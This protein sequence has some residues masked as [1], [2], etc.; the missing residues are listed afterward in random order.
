MNVYAIDDDHSYIKIGTSNLA[1]Q[2]LRP[3]NGQLVYFIVARDEEHLQEIEQKL[4][5]HYGW[6]YQ[7]GLYDRI[8]YL[9]ALSN[10]PD[11]HFDSL[12]TKHKRV[13]DTVLLEPLS[14]KE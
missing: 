8:E 12:V 1:P 9:K 6:S 4:C 7:G 10:K 3:A 11:H 13:W 2:A 14:Y 5:D